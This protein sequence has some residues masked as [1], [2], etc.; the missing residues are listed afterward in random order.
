MTAYDLDIHL[1]ST[2]TKS[3]EQ[4]SGDN[5]IK[6]ENIRLY[7]Q[8]LSYDLYVLLSISYNLSLISMKRVLISFCYNFWDSKW[9]TLHVNNLFTLF[10]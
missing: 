9:F 4:Q 1:A 10:S 2:Q 7:Y 3:D 6:N 8:C 5:L